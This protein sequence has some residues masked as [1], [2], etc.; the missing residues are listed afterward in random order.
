MNLDIAGIDTLVRRLATDLTPA[1]EAGAMGIAATI[2]DTLAPYPPPPPGSTYRRTGQL[3]Q[4]WRIRGIPLGAVLENRV[5]YSRW[6]HGAPGQTKGHAASGWE[7]EESA[8]K[9]VVDG[10]EAQSI[11]EQAIRDRLGVGS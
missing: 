7:N 11:M 3:G 6:V 10:G 9:Q 1:I 5:N 8:I 4:G 2:Q